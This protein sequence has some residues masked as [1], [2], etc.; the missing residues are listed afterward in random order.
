MSQTIS[1]NVQMDA[2]SFRQFA[3][4]DFFRHQRGYRRPAA[5][6]VLL[7]ACAGLCLAQS[8]GHGVIGGIAIALA[9]VGIV[10][11]AIFFGSFYYSLSQQVKRVDLP[12]YELKLDHDGMAAWLAGSMDKAEPTYSSAWSDVFC[13]YR[14]ANVIYI[15]MLRN[16][17]F[18][19]DKDMDAAWQLLSDVLPA[20]KL[21]N[22]R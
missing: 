6:A 22:C 17:A 7:L 4:F 5:F 12:R 14:T 16:Q 9:V 1:A 20:E 8:G 15:Y 19:L 10:I 11:P 2:D 18:L 21:H 13:A 3:V